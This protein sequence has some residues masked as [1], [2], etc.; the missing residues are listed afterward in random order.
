MGPNSN[1]DRPTALSPDCRDLIIY[2]AHEN[3]LQASIVAPRVK[4]REHLVQYRHLLTTGITMLEAVIHD[5]N[6]PQHTQAYSAYILAQV[7]FSETECLDRVLSVLGQGMIIAQ[8]SGLSDLVL[9]MECLNVRALCKTNRNAA[10]IYCNKSLEKY[11][12]M[13]DN[14]AYHALQLLLFDLTLDHSLPQAFDIVKSWETLPDS[15]PKSFLL[16]FGIS[17]ALDNHVGNY[18]E[19]LIILDKLRVFEESSESA[20]TI[21]QLSML[22][23]MVTLLVALRR[24]DDT[25]VQEASKALE[26]QLRSLNREATETE[27]V[28]ENWNIDGTIKLAGI[29]GSTFNIQWITQGQCTPYC[30]YLL[31]TAALRHHTTLQYGRNLLKD[32]L[33]LLDNNEEATHS[34]I[35]KRASFSYISDSLAQ[36]LALKCNVH[37]FM[38]LVNFSG[39]AYKKG[40]RSFERFATL[41]KKLPGEVSDELYPMMCLVAALAAHTS[42]KLKRALKYYN[43]I[44]SDDPLYP[45]AI[46]NLCCLKPSTENMDALKQVIAEMSPE[47]HKLKHAMLELVRLVHDSA[48]MSSLDR[49][50]SMKKIQR[51]V[52]L[53]LTQQL[54]YATKLV[55]V[56][57]FGS[58]AEKNLEL[59]DAFRTAVSE[60]DCVW[61]YVIGEKKKEY[62]HQLGQEEKL[63]QLTSSVENL[64]LHVNCLMENG[65]TS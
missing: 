13:Y 11:K 38:A 50:E 36:K 52:H 45:M 55:C 56:E 63:K 2:L 44:D 15:I 30:Y 24:D 18:E 17:K 27:G 61:A 41:S 39:L 32:C 49:Q 19:T 10:L 62:L 22:R 60:S 46:A 23:T 29:Q 3:I 37:L 65:K 58:T 5:S 33:T 43:R 6:C 48:N 4:T 31:G 57:M 25:P 64:G 12:D 1:S 20:K 9:Q 40:N 54:S 53:G 7:L 14:Y 28:W 35:I 34:G 59:G 51:A 47:H 21:P 26:T 16:L 8:R 42:G